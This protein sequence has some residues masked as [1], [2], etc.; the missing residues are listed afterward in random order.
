MRVPLRVAAIVMG[1]ALVASCGG[2]HGHRLAGKWRLVGSNVNESLV[3]GAGGAWTTLDFRGNRL[4]LH[5]GVEMKFEE[6]DRRLRFSAAGH[7]SEATLE[8]RGDTLVMVHDAG[9][10]QLRYEYLRDR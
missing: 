6:Q 1:A 9:V 4:V 2:G 5:D 7:S 10:L 8:W 3:R